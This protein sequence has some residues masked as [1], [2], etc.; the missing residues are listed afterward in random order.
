MPPC[1]GLQRL[2]L[3]VSNVPAHLT[4]PCIVASMCL[5]EDLR[6]HLTLALQ[7]EVSQASALLVQAAAKRR[8]PQP[9]AHQSPDEDGSDSEGWDTRQLNGYRLVPSDVPTS[10]QFQVFSRFSG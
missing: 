1:I 10:I 3:G 5:Y 2:S 4:A 8:K 6:V 7:T 9:A